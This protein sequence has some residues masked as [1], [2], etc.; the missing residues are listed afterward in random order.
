M[1]LFTSFLVVE[2]KIL[3]N[4]RNQAITTAVNKNRIT[5]TKMNIHHIFTNKNNQ[6]QSYLTHLSLEMFDNFPFANIFGGDLSQNN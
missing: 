6:N 2:N 4:K 1:C 3:K 5:S